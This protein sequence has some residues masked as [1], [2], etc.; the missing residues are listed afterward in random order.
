[1]NICALNE[2]LKSPAKFSPD[3][4]PVWKT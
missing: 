3:G 1:M 4:V 2:Y